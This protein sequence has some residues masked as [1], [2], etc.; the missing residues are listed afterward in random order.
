MMR[1]EI[2]EG[3]VMMIAADSPFGSS[4]SKS[5]WKSATYT[6]E[7]SKTSQESFGDVTVYFEGKTQELGYLVAGSVVLHPGQEPHPPHQHP[8]E[9]FMLVGEG[10]GEILAGGVRTKVGPGGLMFSESNALHGIKNTGSV[11]MRFYYFKWSKQA[12]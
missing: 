10:S 7:G 2:L 9:E 5:P 12:A 6:L 1:R 3:L 8:E 11:P 4:G